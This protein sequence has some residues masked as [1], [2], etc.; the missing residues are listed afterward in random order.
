[1]IYPQRPLA[2]RRALFGVALAMALV[3]RRARAATLPA[4]A[5][6]KDRSC[7]CSCCSGWASHMRTAGFVA[8]AVETGDMAAIKRRFAVPAALQSCHTAT[9]DGY[10]LEGHVPAQDVRRL[11]AERPPA[12][13]L[14]APGMPASAPGMDMPGQPYRVILFG[15]ASGDRVF[16][17]H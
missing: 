6:W 14:A 3:E 1:M 9:L 15:A 10:V 5:V 13:G 11:L 7:S 8:T 17:Q 16:A 12:R 2:T 4:L